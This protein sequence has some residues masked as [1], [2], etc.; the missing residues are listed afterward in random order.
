MERL[1][2]LTYFIILIL[3]ACNAFT[4]EQESPD[5]LLN[6]VDALFANMDNKESPGAAVLI[7]KD[8]KVILNKGYGMAN[9]EY[10]I[11]ITPTT[12]FDIASVSKQFTGFAISLL[13]EQGKIS[14]EDDIRQYIPELADFG[15]T[16]TIGHLIHHTSGLRDW[17]GT[18]SLAGLRMDDVISFSQILTMAFNQKELNFIPG[19]EYSYSNT[20]YN[21][22]AELVQRVTGESFREWTDI[23]IFQPLGM[24][25][26]HF[27]DDHTEIVTNKAYGYFHGGDNMFHAT[28]NNLTALG[29]SS[30]YTT[31]DDLAKWVMN[32]DN[33]KVGGKSVI[34]RMLQQGMLN[35]GE[36][37]SY[38]FG[39][40]IDDY[41]GIKRISHSGGWAS[42]STY[43]AYFPE[44]NFSVVVLNNFP[45][46]P[47]EAAHD[48]A[49]IYLAD[50]LEPQ[51]KEN[52]QDEQVAETV[53]VPI[54]VLDE[55]IGT[56]RLGPAWYVTISRDGD[57]LMTCATAE[58]I[59]PMTATSASTFWIEAYGSSIQFNRDES[60]Q[61]SNFYYRGM[62]CPKLKGISKL[63]SEQLAEFTGEYMSEELKTSYTVA[64]EGDQLVLK[65]DHHGTISLI[66]AWNDDFRGGIWFMNSVEFYRDKEGK[67]NGF[68]VTNNRSRNQ[69]FVKIK[70]DKQIFE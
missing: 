33:S 69:R 45:T 31:I 62:T 8:G 27:H 50:K 5:I 12:V 53:N 65:H 63:I 2:L 56:Y 25:D 13:I 70:S 9:L 41:Q 24:T 40:S 7:V 64:P 21:L 38:A 54:Q 39:L 43:L 60:G 23:N 48:I 11:P 37:I 16:I 4:S 17:P 1:K 52:N 3:S 55:Y 58:D 68:L 66:H 15:H 36:Q 20:G 67:V 14:L 59:F 42:F 57:Q 47:Y 18:L 29:S 61:V 6:K 35:N 22:L 44:Y 32:L 26:T 30:L 46:N 51:N 28:P 34:D 10:K 19:A 49:D